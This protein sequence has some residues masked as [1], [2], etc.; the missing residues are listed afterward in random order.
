MKKV[1]LT[2]ILTAVLA[3]GSAGLACAELAAP[4]V[5]MEV[6]GNYLTLNWNLVPGATGYRI[7]YAPYPSQN[8]WAHFDLGDVSGYSIELNKGAAY[9]VLIRSYNDSGEESQNTAT[10]HF[11]IGNEVHYGLMKGGSQA[12][13]EIRV[14]GM[15]CVDCGDESPIPDGTVL[16]LHSHLKNKIN[17]C[18]NVL[19]IG[20]VH[21]GWVKFIFDNPA[22]FINPGKKS[23][24]VL[25][26]HWITDQWCT[27]GPTECHL[28]IPEPSK[29]A[30]Y[31][32]NCDGNPEL[33]M[34]YYQDKVTP[35]PPG[36]PCTVVGTEC[37]D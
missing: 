21:D 18:N 16:Y 20:V 8:W 7:Y 6:N 22:D 14:W 32:L 25:D 12:L 31:L 27:G 4:D 15:W 30:L 33:G 36:T 37:L 35:V 29:N 1:F 10:D 3:I 19:A 26:R 28:W 17:Y 11:I 34:V 23:S 24:Y 2:L 13:L 9:Y 5:N